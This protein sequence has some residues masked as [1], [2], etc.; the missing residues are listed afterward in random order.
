M[1]IIRDLPPIL[2]KKDWC[3]IDLELFE[4][5]KSKLHR[6]TT[7]KFACLTFCYNEEDVYIITD[8]T[9]VQEA[10]DRVDQAVWIFHNAKFDITHLRRWADVP[11]RARI[12]DT[13]LIDRILWGGYYNLFALNDLARRYLDMEIDK[14]IKS[15]FENATTLDK[16]LIKYSAIDPFITRKICKKQ[17]KLAKSNAIKIWKEVDRDAMWAFIDMMPVRIDIDKWTG[18]ANKNEK[19]TKELAEQFEFNP[20]SSIQTKKYL[21]KNGFPRLRNTQEKTL[22]ARLTNPKQATT[23]AGKITKQLL[24]YR[25][26]QKRSST[27][28][29]NWIKNYVEE[30]DKIYSDYKVIGAETGRTSS[31]RP[32]MQNIPGRATPVYRECFIPHPGHKMLIVDMGQQEARIAAYLSQDKKLIHLFTQTDKD[33]FIEMAKLIYNV[34]ITKSNPLRKQIKNIV[35]GLTY[36]MSPEGFTDRYGGTIT[37]AEKAFNDFFNVFPTL[38]SFL[39]I[40]SLKKQSVSTIMGRKMYLNEYSNQVER[41]AKNSPIQ[42]T[43][44]DQQKVAIGRIYKKWNEQFDFPFSLIM[45]VHDELVFSVP[46]DKVEKV[47]DF[48]VKEM[49][50]AAE[51]QCPGVPFI[52]EA[53]IGSNWS[54]K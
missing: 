31:S 36:G 52:A 11:Y 22:L 1:N 4:A 37:D 42:G 3:A 19:T 16:E 18:I 29:K 41:N 39:H 54:I 49:I 23:K 7:G 14:D 32:N 28:G 26:I 35:Y 20:R 50:Q 8:K 24:Q 33:I 47:K 12:W 25:K 34:K 27:Y 5:K 17:Y 48:V 43:A 44:A 38:A 45:F 21:S 30:D 6:P 40:Q 15:R 9:Q 53:K 13:L 10:L 51:E 46:E 2:S